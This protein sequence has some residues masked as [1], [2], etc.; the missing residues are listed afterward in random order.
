MPFIPANEVFLGSGTMP[1]NDSVTTIG[2]FADNGTRLEFVELS[3]GLA[4]IVAES[5]DTKT[6]TVSYLDTNN[7]LKTESHALNGTTPVLF[8][9]TMTRI[10]KILEPTLSLRGDAISFEDQTPTRTGTAQAGGTNT[11]TLDAGAS[12]TDDFYTG[13][14]IRIT[15]GTGVNQIRRI[16]Q[17][18]GSTKVA[19]V[20]YNWATQPNNTSQFRIATGASMDSSSSGPGTCYQMRVP[21]FDAIASPSSQVVFYEKIFL[22]NDSATGLS[23]SPMSLTDPTG[24]IAFALETTVNAG[25]TNGTGNNRH[26]AP[27]SGV[28]AFGTSPQNLPTTGGF[29]AGDQY[30]IW[31][32]LTLPAGQANVLNTFKLQVTPSGGSAIPLVSENVLVA[33]ILVSGGPV[34]RDARI[35]IEN[36]GPVT[37]DA[38]IPYEN[39]TVGRSARIPIESAQNFIRT[40]ALI[41]IENAG[42]NPFTMAMS[43][44]VRNF[45][46]VSMLQAW[47]V[48]QI[49]LILGR[50]EVWNIRE[51]I[52]SGSIQNTWRVVPGLSPVLPGTSGATNP[53]TAFTDIQLPRAVVTKTP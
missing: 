5:A 3:S 42:T 34:T 48:Q 18:V 12:G 43:W 28:T 41:P 25:G 31:L 17:Y 29:G 20:S 44:N 11:I 16:T 30:G 45:T 19:T 8:S 26:V 40:D 14:V 2:G 37:R 52:F 35:P 50:S 24:L 15:S 6:I 49:L 1:D 21:F 23:T 47:M 13:Q 22:E 38:L 10:L 33:G 7:V 36:L 9:A 27:S 39:F 46:V 32:R 53:N 4:Q 51:T